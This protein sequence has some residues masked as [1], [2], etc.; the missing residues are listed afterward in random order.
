MTFKGSTLPILVVRVLFALVA[1]G[2][3]VVGFSAT[4]RAAPTN[5]VSAGPTTYAC[6]MHPEVV[7][8]TPA[9]CP[10]CRMALEPKK[11]QSKTSPGPAEHEKGAKGGVPVSFSLPNEPEFRAF[12]AVSRTKVYPMSLEMRA[13]AS[14][15]DAETGTALFYLDESELLKPGEEGWFSPQGRRTEDALGVPV[16]VSDAPPVRFDGRTARVRFVAEP[17]AIVPGE[18]GSVKFSTRVR[19]GLVVRAGSL[20][21]S[22]D[23]PHVFVMSDDRRTV[24]R[25]AVE[26]GNVI[27]GYAA[28]VSGLRENENVA[29]RYAFQL[30]IE[31]RR[32]AEATP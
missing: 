2:A 28:I 20:V 7:S 27:Y 23:G 18:I 3:V 22:P 30:D 5:A 31:R 24:T 12:D 9:D 32:L 26:V 21:E 19:R 16:R 17:G 8:A 11:P 4:Y 13:P 1:A 6:P 25:R 15:D 14:V 10:I 29:S